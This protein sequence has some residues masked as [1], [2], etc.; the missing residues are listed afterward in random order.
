MHLIF[1]ETKIKCQL[2]KM[3]QFKNENIIKELRSPTNIVPVLVKFDVCLLLA[4]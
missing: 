3:I 4:A 1:S 2:L